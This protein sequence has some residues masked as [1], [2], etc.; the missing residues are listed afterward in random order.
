MLGILRRLCEGGGRKGDVEELENLA[1]MVTKSSL[2]G[3]GHTAP[4]PVLSTLRHYRHE[5][6]AHIEGKCPAGKCRALITYRIDE[7]CIGC[8]KCAQQCPVGAIALTPHQQHTIDPD[9]CIRCGACRDICPVDA[10]VL[11]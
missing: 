4:N 2:C 3:L 10:V 5:Y 7:P 9:L 8:T 11:D 6:E 1:T